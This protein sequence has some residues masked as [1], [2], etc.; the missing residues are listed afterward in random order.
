MYT[1][2][3]IYSH[4]PLHL[5]RKKILV[6][7]RK[8]SKYYDHYYRSRDQYLWLNVY[9]YKLYN[10]QI[11]QE[12][13]P[14]CTDFTLQVMMTLLQLSHVTN[15]FNV[16]FYFYFYKPY[17]NQTSPEVILAFTNFTLQIMMTLLQ[18]GHVTSIYD[19]S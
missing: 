11:S 12:A 14:T 17:K 7:H 1:V 8:V 6:T 2:F 9:F 18:L 4:T 3:I 15:V 19:L 16:W 10:N 5:W 13:K